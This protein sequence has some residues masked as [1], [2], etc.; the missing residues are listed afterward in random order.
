M[1]FSV[2]KDIDKE[3]NDML[4]LG[5]IERSESPYSSP[6]VMVPKKDGTVRFCVDFRKINMITVFD[7]EPMPNPE[8]LFST[9]T[10][11]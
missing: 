9:L 4:T 10:S 6:V 11:I 8:H 5:V 2:R 1:P 3:I 7:P